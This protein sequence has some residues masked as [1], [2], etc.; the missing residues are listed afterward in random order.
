MRSQNFTSSF[1]VEQE[2]VEVF[3]TTAPAT[4]EA[5]RN[6]A[7]SAC[8]PADDGPQHTPALRSRSKVGRARTPLSRQD[9]SASGPLSRA[10]VR[11]FISPDSR[12]A[13]RCRGSAPRQRLRCSEV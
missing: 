8:S 10:T 9:V 7:G 5:H 2:P 13:R 6:L 12:A 11:I 3:D 4:I 1:T